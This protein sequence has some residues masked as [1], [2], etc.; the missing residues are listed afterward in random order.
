M[1]TWGIV[2]FTLRK[3]LWCLTCFDNFWSEI[4]ILCRVNSV[5]FGG[6]TMMRSWLFLLI[7]W[8]NQVLRSRKIHDFTVP[9][10]LILINILFDFIWIGFI[11]IVWNLL[12]DLSIECFNYLI[13]LAETLELCCKL[14]ILMILHSLH[15]PFEEYLSAEE[16]YHANDH[17]DQVDL[18]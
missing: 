18:K 8:N 15:L 7:R 13:G 1:L 12:H 2:F 6:M 16:Y 3:S 17:G 14:N 5:L 9:L 10:R 11:K 4:L